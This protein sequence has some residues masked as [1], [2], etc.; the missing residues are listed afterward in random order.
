MLPLIVTALLSGQVLNQPLGHLIIAGGG[1]LPPEV[2]GR[3]LILAGGK[4]AHVLIIPQASGRPNAGALSL[5]MWQKAG[6]RQVSIL[7]L[8]DRD[9]ALSAVKGADL[10]WMPGGNQARL[11]RALQ[12]RG[13]ADAIRERFRHGATVGGTSAGAA[14]MSQIMLMGIRPV[15]GVAAAVEVSGL[16]L[17]P[18]V[19]VD[20]HYLRRHRYPRLLN[21]VLHHPDKPGIGIDESTA[22]VVQGRRFEVIGTSRV[23][24]LDARHAGQAPQ[25]H[26]TN[27][28]VAVFTLKSG[29]RF[30]LDK[31]ILAP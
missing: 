22:V 18:D 30:D 26:L 1:P 11:M 31:G 14:V 3:A 23:M 12:E 29:M 4:G 5:A 15:G 7:D 13:L 27:G 16:G 24:V 25:G 20:Q 2:A 8:K 21:A 19:I 9:A 10:I 6:A 28:K 17:W